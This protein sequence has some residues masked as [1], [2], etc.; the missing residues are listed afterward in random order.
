MVDE[1]GQGTVQP[2]A[3][4]LRRLRGGAVGVE[5][6]HGNTIETLGTLLW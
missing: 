1:N 3:S 6:A 5:Q 4:A 2:H